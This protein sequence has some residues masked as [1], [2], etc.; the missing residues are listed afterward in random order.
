M[1]R[2]R[3]TYNDDG[4]TIDEMVIDKAT[5]VHLEQLD[6]GTFMLIVKN[7]RHYWRLTI[8]SRSGRAKV[9]AILYEGR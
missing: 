3:I 6:E 1:A 9:D 8:G 5:L 7:E 4:K 2:E